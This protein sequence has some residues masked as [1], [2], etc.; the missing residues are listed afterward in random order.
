MTAAKTATG[1]DADRDPPR[2]ANPLFTG[3]ERLPE[4]GVVLDG[5]AERVTVKPFLWVGLCHLCLRGVLGQVEGGEGPVLHASRVHRVAAGCHDVRVEVEE[6]RQ[7]TGE[8]AQDARHAT[9][10]DPLKR[11][12][13][14]REQVE[15]GGAQRM[16]PYL[17]DLNQGPAP[18]QRHSPRATTPAASPESA[19][20]D[21]ESRAKP[22]AA[23]SAKPQISNTS[24][25]R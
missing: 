10:R 8:V 7:R 21:S 6:V 14:H 11:R 3:S 16:L 15:V 18:T 12:G 22:K 1:G 23:K 19:S 9:K 17:H 4:A 5:R 25:L 20:S 24:G 13:Q 2:G